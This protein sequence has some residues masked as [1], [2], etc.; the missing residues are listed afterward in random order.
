[1]P[2]PPRV[3]AALRA[4]KNIGFSS[5]DAAPVL[6]KLLEVYENNWEYIEENNY[7]VLIYSIL[8][9]QEAEVKC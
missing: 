5:K 6:K 4:V 7:Q 3:K 2:A 8:E 1:M 9:E